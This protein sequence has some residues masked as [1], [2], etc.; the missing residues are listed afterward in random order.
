MK[1]TPR[2]APFQEVV[3]VVRERGL[4]SAEA[5]ERLAR[6]GPNRT[7]APRQVRFWPILLEEVREPMILLLLAV[8][9]AYFAFGETGEAATVLA[10]VAAVV[11]VEVW[12]EYR[13]KAAVAALEALNAP[14]A[15]VVRDGALAVVPAEEVVP[16]DLL[17][18]RAGMRVV[19][20]GRLVAASELAVDESALT[21]ESLPVE[22]GVG[23]PGSAPADAPPAE[24]SD[25]VF[26]GTVVVRGEGMAVVTATGP[27]TELGR[28]AGLTRAARPP[29]TPLQQAMRELSRMLALAA[30]G[31]AALIPVLL[32]LTGGL[33]WQ[34]AVLTGL[35]LAFATVPEELP[36]LVTMVL[37]LGSL[38]L[39]RERA[40]VRRLHAAETLGHVTVVVTDKT[41]TLTENRLRLVAA[42]PAAEGG[43]APALARAALRSVGIDPR[44]GH[45]VFPE[46]ALDPVR[47]G[48]AGGSGGDTAGDLTDP[49]DRAIWEALSASLSDGA[50]GLGVL[51]RRLPFDEERRWS[52]AVWQAEDGEHTAVKGAP[53]AVLALCG[54][55]VGDPDG[56]LRQ[57]DELA[58]RGYRVLAVAEDGRLQGLLALADPLR[59]EVA[60]A[61]RAVRQA[62]VRVL[63]A[64][65]DHPAVA[66]AIAAE[67]GLDGGRVWTGAE[68]EGLAPDAWDAVAGGAVAGQAAVFA[69]IRPEH[70]LRVV[71]AL[72]RR[73]EVVAMIGDGVN[74]APAL[75]AADVGVAMGRRG[76]DVAREAAGLVL[77]DDRFATLVTAIG[78]GRAL[79]A[80]LQKAVRY[81]LAVKVALVAAMLAPV[82]LGWPPPFPP[83][84][85]VLLELFMD[86]AA[87]TAFVSERPEGDLME[88]PPRDP[89]RPFLD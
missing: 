63:M 41:G 6:Y 4:T 45:P 87:S 88:E 28:V 62:G 49:V 85:I 8:T 58:G 15:A 86:L 48:T 53:E 57:V 29:R 5:A 51:R 60:G 34:E 44:P 43:S 18:L 66:R 74:D 50:A 37:G 68:L 31:F 67:M 30:L 77:T 39:A 61:V 54:A 22:K 7:E 70:K 19:A 69:R 35:S 2:V 1:G 55:G 82:V 65:G 46:P 75:R 10:V 13:A 76:T 23:S 33:A 71:Q 17:V 40:L 84:V 47:A 9:A 36:I 11:L 20:D 79:F 32:A 81:Y 73:G 83:V 21:G 12:T 78:E 14:T 38:R 26:R 64:T 3:A 25:R 72:Q 16:G 56:V 42:E 80:N 24:R 89:T 59:P 27:A 52:G